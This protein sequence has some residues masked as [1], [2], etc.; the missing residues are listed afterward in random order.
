MVIYGE[1]IEI[2]KMQW[3][4]LDV[5]LEKNLRIGR[6]KLTGFN[7]ILKQANSGAVH[8]DQT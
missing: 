1:N 8:P 6:C 4:E 7:G 3:R 5:G 2:G